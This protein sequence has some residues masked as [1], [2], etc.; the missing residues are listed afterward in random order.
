MNKYF[1]WLNHALLIIF[2][3]SYCCTTNQTITLS[4]EYLSICTSRKV[5][6]ITQTQLIYCIQSSSST[7]IK[8]NN[9]YPL[10]STWYLHR[11]WI[12]DKTYPNV[13]E[14]STDCVMFCEIIIV[15]TVLNIH[16]RVKLVYLILI[17]FHPYC[18]LVFYV[19]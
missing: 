10:Y 2:Y 18:I 8:Y 13:Y 16:L 11:C 15:S 3:Y 4:G 9:K 6:P 14:N 7:I 12:C 19:K 5:Q 17:L 1:D